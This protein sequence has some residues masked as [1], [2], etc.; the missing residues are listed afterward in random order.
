[1]R[2]LLLVLAG[3][4][5]FCLITYFLL[6]FVA[7]W[8]GQEHIQSDEDISNIYLVFLGVLG[9]SIVIGALAGDFIHKSLTKR[10]SGRAKGARR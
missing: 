2:R 5:L 10:S 6:G 1:M 3:S 4:L 7:N 9:M 8:Y